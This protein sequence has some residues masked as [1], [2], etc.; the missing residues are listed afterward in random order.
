[1][2][3]D[4]LERAGI[5][6]YT[7]V[8]PGPSVHAKAARGAMARHVAVNKITRPEGLKAFRGVAGEWSFAEETKPRTFVFKVR[9]IHWSP[10]DRVGVVNAVS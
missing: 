7:C 2:R 6:T 9:S 5:P 10:Y 3:A 4:V 8:F 1:M